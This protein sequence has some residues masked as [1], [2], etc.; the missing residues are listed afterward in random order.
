MKV[1][2]G[3]ASFYS[4]VPCVLTIGNFDG[5]HRG[6][7]ALLIKAK[8]D[9]KEN[10]LKLVVMTFEPHPR[11]FFDAQQAPLRLTLWRDQIC[12]LLECGVDQVI[13]ARFDKHFAKQSHELFVTQTLINTLR[14]KIIYV[15]D[16]FR[17]GFQRAGNINTLK[18]AGLRYHFD[19][20]QIKT[21][22]GDDGLRISSTRVRQ[23]LANG[24]IHKANHLLGHPY[25][26]SGRVIHGK[27]L[28]RT[29][30]FPTL[31]IR[32]VHNRPALI[33]ILLVKVWGLSSQPMLGVASIGKRPT[34]DHSGR[35][36]L[37]VHVLDWQGDAYGKLVTIEFLHKLHDEIHY[38]NLEKLV[39]G[40]TQ[41]VFQAR[42]WFAQHSSIS[43]INDCS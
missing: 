10:G 19:V 29:L 31:N 23:A 9:A 27:Q 8:A 20:K 6:H 40:I 32:I 25:Q 16:D 37:E 12:A 18:Q 13:M 21:I 36:L 38:A 5:V 26:M 17:Y 4:T 15:G 30:G 35:Y 42:Q 34:V 28:G 3:L 22:A 41:D 1:F 39:A 43:G 24:E 11:E 2:Q 7:R 33:G 14:A